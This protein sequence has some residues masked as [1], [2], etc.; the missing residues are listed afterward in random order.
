M[1]DVPCNRIQRS[2][3]VVSFVDWSLILIFSENNSHLHHYSI[4][5]KSKR[6]FVFVFVLYKVL[7]GSRP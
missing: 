2:V 4:C 7:N 6:Y 3:V 5:F 1:N